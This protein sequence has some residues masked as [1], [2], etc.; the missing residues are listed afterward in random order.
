MAGRLRVRRPSPTTVSFTV[1]N[2]PRRANTPAKIL[3]GLQILLRA[4]LL[5]GV[6]VIGVAKSQRIF[7]D[8]NRWA[9]SWQPLWSSLNGTYVSQLVDSYNPWLIAGACAVVVYGVFRRGYTGM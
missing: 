5:I 7:P 9:P 1:S 4:L 6:I 2:A 3:F 8:I